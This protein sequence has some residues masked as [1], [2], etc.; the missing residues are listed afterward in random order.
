[1]WTIAVKRMQGEFVRR[2]LPP[3]T[4]DEQALVLDYLQHHSAK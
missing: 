4:A 3:L 1:M 2:G